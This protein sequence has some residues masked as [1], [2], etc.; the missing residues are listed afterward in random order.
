MVCSQNEI[1][2]DSLRLG[3]GWSGRA[4]LSDLSGGLKFSQAD[5]LKC[6]SQPHL[7]FED[8]EK[9]IKVE[10]RNSVVLKNLAIASTS[11]KAV[12][13]WNWPAAG[14]CQF[15]RS[16]RSGRAMRNFDTALMLH[17]LGI[18][19]ANPLAALQERFGP[20]TRQSIYITRYLEGSFD[21][22]AFCRQRLSGGRLSL[23]KNLADQLASILATLHQNGLWHRDSKAN[24]FLVTAQDGNKYKILLTDMDGIKPY[25]LRRKTCRLRSLWQL[26]ASLMSI[27]AVN[28]TDYLRVFTAYCELTG[29]DPSHRRGIFRR[30]SDKAEAK[31]QR[32]AA[33]KIL[34]IKPSSLGDV[35]MALPALSALRRSFPDAKIS[36]F[37]RPEFAPLLKNHPDLDE[38]ILFDRRFLGKAL[39]NPQAFAALISLIWRLNRSKFDIVI[40]LQGLFRTA[41]FAW[42]SGCPKRF[43][44]ANAGEFGHLFYTHKVEQTK[45]CIHLVDY[46]LEIVR[47]AGASK[48][49]VQFL[50]PADSVAE[51]TVKR[52]LAANDI[53]Q[54]NY[55]V[56]VTT[57]AHEDKCWPVERFAALADK[58]SKQ[59]GLSIIATGSA[60]EKPI[61]ERLK[62]KANVPITNF[63]GVTS[64]GELVALLKGARLVVSN[65]TG[66]GHI[67]AALGVPVV[68]LFGRSNPARVAPYGR[69]NCVAA[70]DP[71]GRGF[72][73]DSTDP[74]HD[75]KAITVDEVYQKV[76]EQLG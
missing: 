28:R 69:P 50:L 24:N 72:E 4:V 37:I 20:F 7:L 42:L 40:D 58:I 73:A 25:R 60:S 70:V 38:V 17:R 29:I 66:P 8:V 57:S 1:Q 12:I 61:V 64:I 33:R 30:L 68:L 26:A 56:L 11:L 76:C 19:A 67:A 9:T 13:K 35:V 39:F 48:I 71:T 59:F 21:L 6:L 41:I 63:A 16:L 18:P 75:I 52:L 65:D 2:I 55:A 32:M 51:G 15:F 22:H 45:D 43:G 74:K 46:Y 34:I 14:F 36:W 49:D 27:S 62:H 44:M 10:G 54:D 23:R 5:W 3:N 53:G 47:Q 31:Y